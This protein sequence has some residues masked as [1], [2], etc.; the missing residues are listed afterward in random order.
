[1]AEERRPDDEHRD[2]RAA[3][4]PADEAPER[5]DAEERDPESV[6]SPGPLGNPKSDEEELSHRQ[7]ER[8]RPD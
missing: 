4:R 2:E 5:D 6:R 1:M 3:E 8:D 7:Q